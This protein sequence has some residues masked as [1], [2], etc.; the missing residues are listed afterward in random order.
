MPTP[1][2]IPV[3]IKEIIRHTNEIKTFILEP[4][5][6]LPR[7]KPGQF[8]HFAIDEYNQSNQ[9]PDSRVFSIASSPLIKNFL[10]ITFIIKGRYTKRMYDEV[11]VGDKCW[12]KL[13]YGN[14]TFD[15]NEDIVLIAGG[16]GITPFI[17]FLEY[18]EQTNV[19]NS[20]KLYYG[21][22]QI[23]NLIYD[24]LISVC[25]KS[26][27]NFNYELF[28]ENDDNVKIDYTNGILDIRKIINN[29]IT[30]KK[31]KYYLCGPN[32]MIA[33]FK[34]ELINSGISVERIILDEW[35]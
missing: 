18:S 19:N 17:S 20:I 4:Q 28:I 7:F 30:E 10:R 31:S 12:I 6:L 11:N 3:I 34:D 21:I 8:L 14:F 1:Q 32:Q 27:P 9:W 35:E 22:K 15:L 26:L 33:S 16:T 13:P 25:K 5:K 23:D 24:D 29:N 2:K